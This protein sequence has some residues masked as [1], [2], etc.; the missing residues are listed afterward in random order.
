MEQVLHGTLELWRN[1]LRLVRDVE[2]RKLERLVIRLMDAS[3]DLNHGCLTSSVLAEHDDDLGSIE[4]TRSN[5]DLELTKRLD[6]V[7]IVVVRVLEDLFLLNLFSG[8]LTSILFH[9][10][11]G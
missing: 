8:E 1:R 7:W 11:L 3:Q 6:H 2:S 4:S 9:V 10:S 5:I